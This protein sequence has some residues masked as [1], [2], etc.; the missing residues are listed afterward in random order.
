MS[1]IFL[2]APIESPSGGSATQKP[3]PFYQLIKGLCYFLLLLASQVTVSTA[4]TF[5]YA[6]QKGLAD[7]AAG[8]S[9]SPEALS[10]YAEEQLYHHINVYLIA[11]GLFFILTVF[12][13]FLIRRKNVWVETCIRRFSPKFLPGLLMLALGLLLFT[14]SVLSLLPAAWIADYSEASSFI[15]EGTL[16]GSLISQGLVAP[17]TEELA[18]RGLMLSRFNKGVPTWIGIGISSVFFGILHGDL[19]WFIYAALLGVA[20]CVVANLTGSIL[21]TILLHSMF[22]VLGTL[23]SYVPLEIP[24]NAVYAFVILGFLLI[25]LGF[26]LIYKGS[27][28][29]ASSE[30]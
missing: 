25:I 19:L 11:Y 6:Y 27:K 24:L 7:Q 9:L 30:V 22:N 10:A 13:I 28:K 4:L 23:L 15:T 20:F 18:F 1:D 16:I 29:S 17:I 12:L 8:I 26:Y 2:E 5:Y 21:T 14:N 3:N